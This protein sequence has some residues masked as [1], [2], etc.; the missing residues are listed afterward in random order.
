[1]LCRRC[2]ADFEP[3]H[4]NARY[5][6]DQCR[7]AS[8]KERERARDRRRYGASKA[9]EQVALCA[10][11]QRPASRYRSACES[12]YQRA[13]YQK[14]RLVPKT[15]GQCGL[16][17]RG[18]RRSICHRCL[19]AAKP[20]PMRLCSGCGCPTMDQ[21]KQLCPW[22]RETRPVKKRKWATKTNTTARGYGRAYQLARKRL[23]ADNPPCHWCGAPATTADHEP[24]VA[25]AGPHLNLVPACGPCNFGRNNNLRWERRRAISASRVW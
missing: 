22:C 14:A 2:S 21:R 23:L 10:T 3:E 8:H 7:D 12:C 18:P 11:C 6:S 20:R 16:T 15:C 1:M 25:I 5:C 24:P 17:Y 9:T 19:Y 4:G 13:R